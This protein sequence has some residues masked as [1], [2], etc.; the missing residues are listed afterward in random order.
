MEKWSFHRVPKLRLFNDIYQFVV[1]ADT[2]TESSVLCTLFLRL[3]GGVAEREQEYSMV[4]IVSN[5]HHTFGGN[6]FCHAPRFVLIV[7]D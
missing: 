1:L 2:L 3:W 4:L 7:P 6:R 5:A